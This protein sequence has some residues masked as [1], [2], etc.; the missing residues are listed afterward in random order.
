MVAA[1]FVALVGS[2]FVTQNIRYHLELSDVGILSRTLDDRFFKPRF[3]P[4][5]DLDSVEMLATG[6]GKL[7]LWQEGIKLKSRSGAKGIYIPMSGLSRNDQQAVWET[8]RSHLPAGGE[9][10]PKSG[11]V[12]GRLG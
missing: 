5:D 11:R 10:K 1:G 8:I 3:M 4:W 9:A 12:Q 2:V 6:I 7:Q